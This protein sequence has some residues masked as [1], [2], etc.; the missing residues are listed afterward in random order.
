M[1]LAESNME[2]VSEIKVLEKDVK[3]MKHL[4]L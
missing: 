3:L 4:K 1:H 2:D